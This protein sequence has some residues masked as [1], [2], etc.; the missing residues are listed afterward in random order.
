MNPSLSFAFYAEKG[1]L[2]LKY[3]YYVKK[4]KLVFVDTRRILR[5]EWCL[6]PTKM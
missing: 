2:L 3:Q 1:G 4:S 6:I 5:I